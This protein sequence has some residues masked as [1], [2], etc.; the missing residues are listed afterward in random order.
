M[1]NSTVGN[2]DGKVNYD[3]TFMSQL[4]SQE[5]RSDGLSF[6]VQ[7][8]FT[9]SRLTFNVGL[10]AEQWKHFASTGDGDLHVRLGGGAAPERRVTTSAATASRRSTATTA[11]TTIRSATT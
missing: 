11:A 1:F 8:Q 4:G 2:P 9:Y 10:R 3:R 7:D 6:F 5:T